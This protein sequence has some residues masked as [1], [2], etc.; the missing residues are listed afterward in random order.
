MRPVQCVNQANTI[1]VRIPAPKAPVNH[2]LGVST[3]TRAL[4]AAPRVQ[5][6]TGPTAC[7]AIVSS[8]LQVLTQAPDPH[9]A[10][11]AHVD[12]ILL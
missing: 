3:V 7:I 6:A 4:Q 12:I 2:A 11:C 10:C 9:G 8:A 1:P 5:Q